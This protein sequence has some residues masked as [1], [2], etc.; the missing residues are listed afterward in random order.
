MRGVGTTFRA[1]LVLVSTALLPVAVQ[2]ADGAPR[3]PE[4]APQIAPSPAVV[5]ARLARVQATLADLRARE[6]AIEAERAA[7]NARLAAA[8]RSLA[9]AQRRL[10]LRLRALYEQEETHPLEVVLGAS[11]FR[12]ALTELDSLERA[13][14]LDRAWIERSR[15]LREELSGLSR[16]LAERA[17]RTRSLRRSA[18]T[19]ARSLEALRHELAQRAVRAR[20]RAGQARTVAT[21]APT[22]SAPTAAPAVPP[23][24]APPPAAAT[25]RGQT[26]TVV[27]TAYALPGFTATGSAVGPGT[28]AVDPAVIPFG[29]HLSIPGYGIGVAADTGPAIRGARIDVWFET[30]EQARAWGT[31]TVEVTFIEG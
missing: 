5:D 6:R 3:Q 29:T 13:A 2:A 4:T 9:V 23:A 10:G 16:S 1:L 27:A 12:A 26:L 17:T 15:G 25:E 21:A 14:R 24:T 19:T 28:I 31:R 7:I 22:A 18:E 30:I 8:R 11:S 20:V